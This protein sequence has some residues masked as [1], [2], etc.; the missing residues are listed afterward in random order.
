MA[1]NVMQKV[2]FISDCLYVHLGQ[3]DDVNIETISYLYK[4]SS[5]ILCIYLVYWNT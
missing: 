1:D 2:T 4:I 3:N 5:N